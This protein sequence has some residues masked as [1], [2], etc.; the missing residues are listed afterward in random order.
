MRSNGLMLNNRFAAPSTH[1]KP[2]PRTSPLDVRLALDHDRLPRA[3]DRMREPERK[4]DHPARLVRAQR[5]PYNIR[6][7]AS[8]NAISRTAGCSAGVSAAI[9]SGSGSGKSSGFLRVARRWG[10][11]NVRVL[12]VWVRI[13]LGGRHSI[14]IEAIV[15]DSKYTRGWDR[16]A[17]RKETPAY[18]LAVIWADGDL[19]YICYTTKSLYLSFNLPNGYVLRPVKCVL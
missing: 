18:R 13:A 1:I 8:K 7:R 17:W 6:V 4:R 16:D 3:R 2:H 14:L 15:V 5:R 19:L 9:C 11:S 12:Q 10:Q